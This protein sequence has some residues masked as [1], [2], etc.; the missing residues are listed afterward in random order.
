MTN[1][2]DII[3]HE[4]RGMAAV[5]HCLDHVTLDIRQGRAQPDFELFEAIVEYVEAFPD[6]IHH[7]KEEEYLFKVLEERAPELKDVIARQREEHERCD[8]ATAGLREAL[9]AYSRDEEGARD[10]FFRAVEEFLE[11]ERKHMSR[12]ERLIL[13]KAREVLSEDDMKRLDAAFA[14]NK[15]PLF[16][17]EPSTRFRKLFSKIVAIAPQPYGLGTRQSAQ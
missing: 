2:I 6:A 13:P 14:D 10:R 9:E 16:G 17:P 11:F 5:L 15:D 3:H 1:A 8:A 4:H 12:E 7:P